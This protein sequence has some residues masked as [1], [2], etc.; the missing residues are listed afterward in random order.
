MSASTH[1]VQTL[2]VP[3]L[4]EVISVVHVGQAMLRLTV[5]TTASRSTNAFII[6]IN[7]TVSTQNALTSQV[8]F[9][10]SAELAINSFQAVRMSAKIL[11]SVK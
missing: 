6:F 3:T 1:P 2:A 8:H 7:T 10:A 5:R 4:L 9:D 11:T